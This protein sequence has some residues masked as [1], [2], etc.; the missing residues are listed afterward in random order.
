MLGTGIALKAINGKLKP[1]FGK[2]RYV[3]L[4]IFG[5]FILISI[6]MIILGIVTLNYEWI[7]MPSIL[8]L[9]STYLMCISSIMVRN[10]YQGR[11][12]W[13]P[14]LCSRGIPGSAWPMG[15]ETCFQFFTK[16]FRAR[17]IHKCVGGW[18]CC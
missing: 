4:A 10:V 18:V 3:G 2:S 16:S 6:V 12:H 9:S 13:T 7:I 11:G 5:S 15:P 1:K 17:L 8:I 14:A